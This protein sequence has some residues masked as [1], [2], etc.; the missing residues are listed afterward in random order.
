MEA[1]IEVRDKCC[2]NVENIGTTDRMHGEACCAKWRVIHKAVIVT[3]GF[4][5]DEDRP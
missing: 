1:A 3:I 4:E 2:P 5:K